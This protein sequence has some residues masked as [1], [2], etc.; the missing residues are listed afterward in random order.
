M[1][2][3]LVAKE[4]E[5]IAMNKSGKIYGFQEKVLERTKGNTVPTICIGSDG[6]TWED[7]TYDETYWKKFFPQKK[8]GEN[9][10]IHR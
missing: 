10:F 2:E 3:P 4:I 6:I 9:F 1:N 5:Q 7:F 8:P